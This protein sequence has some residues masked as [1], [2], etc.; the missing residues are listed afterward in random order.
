MAIKNRLELRLA[1]L[2]SVGLLVFSIVAGLFTYHFAF[3]VRIAASERLQE[4]LVRTIQAQAEVAAYTGNAR[5]AEGV[6]NGLLANPIIRGVQIV[7]F[8]HFKQMGGSASAN[9]YAL[10]SHCARR[11]MIG[12]TWVI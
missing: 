9:E 10:V 5:I 7:T 4:Q 8:E 6:I 12:N 3:Q 11:S 2:V 1:V